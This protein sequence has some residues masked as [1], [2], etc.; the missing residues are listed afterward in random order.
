MG[1]HFKI[2]NFKR[3][4]CYMWKMINLWKNIKTLRK[5]WKFQRNVKKNKFTKVLEKVTFGK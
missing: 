3:E 4:I 5:W 2:L 1:R